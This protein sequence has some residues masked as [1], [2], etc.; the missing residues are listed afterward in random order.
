MDNEELRKLLQ[1]LH[2]EIKNTQTV[3][4]KGSELLRD[5]EGDLRALLERSEEN[6]VQLHPSI[7]QRMEGALNHFEATHS[8]LTM[9][10]SKL[11]DS[12]SNAG[13]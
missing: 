1:Q 4:E 6:P 5:L 12:L 8:D 10:I 9:L 11:L 2:D 3:D 7:V 13:I